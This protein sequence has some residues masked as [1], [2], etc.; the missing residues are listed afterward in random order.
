MFERERL[1]T[2]AFRVGYISLV[3]MLLLPL[4]IIISTSIT[5][6]S[7]LS[8]P[9]KEISLQW[10]QNFLDSDQWIAAMKNS[11]ITS[12]G[13]MVLST[14]L[15][16]LAALG[17]EG[18]RG[19]L[20]T[21]LVPLVLLPLLIPAVVTAVTLLTF[22]SELGIQQSYIGIILAHSLWATPL[23]FFIMQSVFARFDW[24]LRDA[25]LD[26]GASPIR[27]FWEVVLPG[28]R[29]GIFASM[30][31]AFIISLQEFI[32]ALFL[33]GFSTRTVPVL[34]YI[35]LREILDPLVSVVSTVMIGAAVIIVIGAS[36]AIGLNQLSQNL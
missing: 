31:I 32:M 21:Y 11:L 15:G 28:V 9:P 29:N 33:S 4:V 20:S 7:Y 26:L 19:K 10:Y 34:A 6:S 35:S 18:S 27:A 36:L 16:V 22:Y 13:T 5:E 1:E 3:V 25:G 24:S 23:V 2:A 30:L 12:T 14:T 17:V 8:F